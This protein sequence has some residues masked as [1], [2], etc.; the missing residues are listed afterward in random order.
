MNVRGEVHA[1]LPPDHY[2]RLKLEAAARRV[3]LSQC[4]GD[5]LGEYFTLREE[6]ATRSARRPTSPAIEPY[7]RVA[8]RSNPRAPA[9]LAASLAPARPHRP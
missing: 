3:S 6:M 5:C 4:V 1:Y 2:R 8:A 7:P 9:R